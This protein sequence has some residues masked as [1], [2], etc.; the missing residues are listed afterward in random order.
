MTSSANGL[1][2]LR[3]CQRCN[4]KLP[5]VAALIS[6]HDINESKA[7]AFRSV[8]FNIIKKLDNNKP[9]IFSDMLCIVLCF[10]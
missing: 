2:I 8:D 6:L 5:C 3:P 9:T 7:K 4:V 10:V 1:G